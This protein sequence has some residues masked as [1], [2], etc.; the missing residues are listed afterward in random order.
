MKKSIRKSLA[1]AAISALALSLTSM[2]AFASKKPA[3]KPKVTKKATPTPTQAKPTVLRVTRM[4]DTSQAFGPTRNSSGNDHFVNA[5]IFSNL[6][7]IAPDEKTILPDLA[8]KWTI[9]KDAK[10]FTF[11]LNKNVKWHDGQPFTADDVVFTITMRCR[12]GSAA[13]EGYQATQWDLIEGCKDLNGKAEGTPS[14]LTK[15]DNYTVKMKLVQSNSQFV[16]LI[17]DAVYSIIPK[18][19]NDGLELKEYKVSDFVVAE[20]IG[21]GPY[22]LTKFK[23]NQY[24]ELDANP[25]YFRGKPSINKIF[26]LVNVKPTNILP[27]LQKGELDLAIDIDVNLEDQ[28]SKLTSYNTKWNNTVAGQFFQFHVNNAM[29][30]DKRVRQAVWYAIDR[31]SMLKNLFGGH[32]EIRWMFSGFDQDAGSLDKYEYNPTKA[33]ELIKASGVDTSKDFVIMYSPLTDPAWPKIVPVMKE[34]LEAVGLK[35]KL[36][37]VDQAAWVAKQREKD[38]SYALTLN[39]GGSLGLGVSRS[40]QYF[41]CKSPLNSWYANCAL[42]QL[43]LDYLAETDAAEQKKIE[44]KIAAIVNDQVPFMTTWEKQTFNAISKKLGGKFSLYA[45]DRD[46]SFNIHEWVMSN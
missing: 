27:L 32:G 29:V 45:N 4:G 30:S 18:H 37:P 2:P 35:V 40:A 16:R 9:S 36:E 28:V 46:S 31:R 39:S 10:E 33:K 24:M 12:W 22:K 5:L 26:W 19:I 41:N 3:A 20:P 6:V 42:D 8:S 43:Y 38:G 25:N 7:K 15:V 23:R 21:T 17:T 1:L 14:G 34:Q 13:Y 44:G 11:E